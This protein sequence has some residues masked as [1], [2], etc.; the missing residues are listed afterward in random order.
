[1]TEDQKPKHQAY[2]VP[3]LLEGTPN[4]VGLYERLEEL[5]TRVASGRLAGIR[6]G[7]SVIDEKMGGLQNGLHILAAEPAA[8]KTT[9]ALQLALESAKDGGAAIYFAFDENADRLAMKLASIVAGAIPSEIMS[10]RGD[11]DSVRLAVETNRAMLDRIRIYGESVI[12]PSHL[13]SLLQEIKEILDT[14]EVL[15]VV[16]FL[17]S[18]AG[19]LSKAKGMD[20]RIAVNDLVGQLRDISKN[21]AVPIL[22]ITAQNRQGQGDAKMTSLRESSDLEYGADSILFLS[23]EESQKT[24]PKRIVELTCVKNR[25]GELFKTDLEFYA[26]KSQFRVKSGSFK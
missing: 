20:Y 14:N 10:G 11:L 18:L 17:Q 4:F 23:I 2:G 24:F 15:V 6:T 3:T 7:I 8:G 21:N 22:A 12:D 9:F 19:R 5:R 26:A 13:E 16:D 25:Y 1:M